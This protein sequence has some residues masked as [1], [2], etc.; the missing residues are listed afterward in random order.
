MYI[1]RGVAAHATDYNVLAVFV[2]FQHGA[3]TSTKL[4]P[5]FSRYQDLPLGC[6]LRIRDGHKITL[7]TT[8]R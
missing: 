4:P 5:N 6:Q 2:P 3:W 1:L 7:I 8:V